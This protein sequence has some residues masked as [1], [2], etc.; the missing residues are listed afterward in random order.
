MCAVLD[1][2]AV[3]EVMAYVINTS[4]KPSDKNLIG[5]LGG[6]GSEKDVM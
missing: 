6:S 2:S 4:H 1:A 3:Q 5:V